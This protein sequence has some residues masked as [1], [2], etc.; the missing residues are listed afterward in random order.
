MNRATSPASARSIHRS[1]GSW[2]RSPRTIRRP[3]PASPSPMTT[4]GP[5][6]MGVRV[7]RP[8]SRPTGLGQFVSPGPAAAT[9]P[10]RRP[11]PFTMTIHPLAQGTCDHRHQE[12]GYQ[13]SRR[14]R[15]LVEAR[16]TTCCAPGCRR[17]AAQCDLDHTIPYDQG[18]R[19]CE[20]DLA[21]LCRHHHRCKQSEGWR[22]EQPQ[23][24][25]LRWTTPAGRQYTDPARR[26]CLGAHERAQARVDVPVHR[27]A[28]SAGSAAGPGRGAV[29][30]ACRA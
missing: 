10:R 24:G 9:A 2:P 11:G 29:P 5:S 22:L 3:V 17:P 7:A 8:P 1:P 21:P 26:L 16:T 19:T 6:A 20:C 14:L 13:P 23:P 28:S 30:G 18:G 12:P 4:G 25:I 15:H 27:A